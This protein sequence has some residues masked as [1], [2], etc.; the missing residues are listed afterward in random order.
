M[1]P[2]DGQIE[3]LYQD[4]YLLS[5]CEH[6][7]ISPFDPTKNVFNAILNMLPTAAH[8]PMVRFSVWFDAARIDV[9]WT[10]VPTSARPIRYKKMERDHNLEG[11]FLGDA[12]LMTVGF[13]YQYND[14]NSKNIEVIQEL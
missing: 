10:Q 4:G 11:I 12:R 5:E 1:T 9:D 8:G 3:A 2:N 6:M 14:D 7:D 13:G